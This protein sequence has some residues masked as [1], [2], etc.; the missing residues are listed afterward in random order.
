[1][2]MA[3]IMR[4][5]AEQAHAVLEELVQLLQDVVKSGASVGFLPPLSD[6][7]A[8]D[9]WVETIEDV[10]R[11]QRILLLAVQHGVVVGAV[12]LALAGQQNGQH[13]AEVQKLMVHTQARRQGT[14]Q[15]LMTA[16][17]AVAQTAGRTL[18]VLDTRHGDTAEQLYLKQGYVLA[19]IIP[20]YA[21][22][23]NGD[24]HA[25]AIFYRLI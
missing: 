1:M 13:R 3:T 22:S 10:S 5:T 17:E 20:Q 18:L 8:R 12:Q 25:T 14:G 7:L 2:T 4:A 15:A 11:G 16:I 23:A 19:G 9:Y 6:E 24:L 21:R